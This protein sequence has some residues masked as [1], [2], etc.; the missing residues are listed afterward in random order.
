M[1]R[2]EPNSLKEITD[3]MERLFNFFNEK[4]Y[5]SKLERPVLRIHLGKLGR[6]TTESWVS[7]IRLNKGNETIYELNFIAE[8]MQR[9]TKKNIP[10]IVCAL[11][12][13]MVHLS[14]EQNNI[15]DMAGNGAHLRKTFA[16]LAK[17][18]GLMI[19]FKDNYPRIITPDLSYEGVIYYNEF[20]FNESL[21]NVFH[22]LP[23][24]E[25]P[26]NQEH[27]S[28]SEA[29]DNK[30]IK[31]PKLKNLFCPSCSIK[32]YVAYGLK[33]VIIC[34]ACNIALVEKNN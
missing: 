8:L 20:R 15:Q 4:F 34:G 26:A 21:L 27:Q 16:V 13:E 2:L 12:H 29:N 30:P 32:A 31:K 22:T 25:I 3:E 18:K 14:N 28:S 6:K 23:N 9:R 17:A 19:E 10:E 7:K 11:L 5:L 1:E 33:T 24:L